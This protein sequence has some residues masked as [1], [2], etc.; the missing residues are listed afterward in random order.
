M[1][2]RANSAGLRELREQRV[3]EALV[4]EASVEALDEGVLRGL[5][6]GDVMPCD[7]GLLAERSIVK[8][9]HARRWLTACTVQA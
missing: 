7:V 5:A 2:L 6:G 9:R 4:P 8:A 3:V 1:D